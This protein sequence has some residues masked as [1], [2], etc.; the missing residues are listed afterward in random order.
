MLVADE[1]LET[2]LDLALTSLAQVAATGNNDEKIKASVALLQ[3]VNLAYENNRKSAVASK[4][5]PLLESVTRNLA[6]QLT[7]EDA[8][9]PAFALDPTQQASLLM[10]FSKQLG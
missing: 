6:G 8:W 1:K 2:A 10:S 4:V 9:A 3:G 7:E 5:F